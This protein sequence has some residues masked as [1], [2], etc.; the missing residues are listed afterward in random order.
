M[1]KAD[2]EKIEMKCE[3]IASKLLISINKKKAYMVSEFQ[4][5][6]EKHRKDVL[7]KLKSILE[8]IF[9]ILNATYEPFVGCRR[10]TQLVWFK[11]V[12]SIDHKI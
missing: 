11:Y 5:E 2:T 7:V 12:N 3:E 8:E 10:E 9:N 1:F 6:Q 4:Q